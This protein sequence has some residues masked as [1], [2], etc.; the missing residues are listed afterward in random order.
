MPIGTRLEHTVDIVRSTTT[1]S[2]DDYNQPV[3][4][5]GVFATIKAAIQPKDAEEQAAVSQAGAGI[6]DH[7]IYT[8]PV[9][10][11]GGDAVVHDQGDC[12]MD[13]DLPTMRFEVGGIRNAAGR[14]HHL[15]IDARAVQ[16]E[17]DVTGS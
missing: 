7:T 16:P 5:P 2:Y 15:E 12:P 14:G 3:T 13:P 4:T 17:Q 10:I 9:D 11:A 1:G 6:S 8:L